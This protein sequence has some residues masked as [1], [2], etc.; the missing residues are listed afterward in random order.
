MIASTQSNSPFAA[1]E[2]DDSGDRDLLVAKLRTFGLRVT[3]PRIALL[4]ALA[5]AGQP[6][7]IDQLFSRTGDQTCDLVTI[8][9]TMAAFEKAG[10]VYRSGF[11]A[12]GAALFSVVTSG[13]RK[14]PLLCKGSAVA[15]ELDDESSREL[16]VTIERIRNRLRARG[17]GELEHIVE[18][19]AVGPSR[20]G[21]AGL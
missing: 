9:R 6:L 19:F 20:A 17:Y 12:R 16:R 11:S 14:Y 1:A 21:D 18:F 8:Y 10:V 13:A 7:T 15:E 2:H 3:S 4:N 5:S